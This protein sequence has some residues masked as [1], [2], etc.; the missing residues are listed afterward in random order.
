MVSYRSNGKLLL[1]G[2][3]VV[4][5][6]AKA[7]AIPCKK[8]Q[9]LNYQPN[10]SHL[11]VWKS[12]DE[13][14]NIWFETQFDINTFD[15]KS[16]TDMRLWN[17]LQKLLQASRGL[18]PHFLPQGGE[19]ETILEFNR[20]WGLGSSSTLVS[21][22]ALWA[23]VNPYL[24]LERS[25]GGSGYDIACA[26]AKSPITFIRDL[27]Q[28]KIEPVQLSYPFLHNLF[29]V[30]LNQKKDSQEAVASF[31]L[32]RI[33]PSV[34]DQ[35]DQLTEKLICCSNQKEFNS[36]L[37][38]HE[39]ILGKLLNQQTVQEMYFSDFDGAIKSLGAWG[40]DFVLASG[41]KQS[42]AY[43]EKKGYK[44]LISFEEMIL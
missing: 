5:K 12:R 38:S 32:N 13:F 27:Y 37:I 10:E 31:D 14:G 24:L 25:F 29:F 4:L 26:Q 1:T 36:H 28:P 43:F 16:S 20:S 39:K 8:G 7:L 2:E 6:G 9:I 23:D 40:G 33:T 34:L 42:K 22:L 19:V 3:Y 17:N 21:N 18:N 44:T 41:S 35:I 15:A 30:Y 11:L